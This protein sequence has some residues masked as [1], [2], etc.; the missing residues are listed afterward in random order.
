MGGYCYLNNAAIAAQA[1][2][3]SGHQ[4]VAILDVD[5]HHG[6]GTQDIFYERND[7][8]YLSIHGHPDVEYPH[9]WGYANETG[10]AAGVGWNH[11]VPLNLKTTD[12]EIYAAALDLCLEKIRGFK[13]DCVI[14]SLG[15]DTFE[16]DPMAEFKLK[17][18]DY[19]LM[20]KVIASLCSPTLFVFEGGYA[21]DQLGV[22]TVNVLTGF[23]DFGR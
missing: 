22:N 6:N 21:I 1:C 16:Q 20:G 23:E 12:W 2:I 8:F 5:Y 18:E 17:S 14:V 3:D 11:N 9:F 19:L 15:L 4:R 7:V 10:H 13:P